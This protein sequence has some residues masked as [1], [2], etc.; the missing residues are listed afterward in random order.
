V[1]SISRLRKLF[2]LAPLLVLLVAVLLPEGIVAAAVALL[3]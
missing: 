2:S 3:T 1:P